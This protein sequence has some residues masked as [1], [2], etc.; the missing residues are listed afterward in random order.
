MKNLTI[1]LIIMLLCSGYGGKINARAR[2]L[3]RRHDQAVSRANYHQRMM[4]RYNDRA[5]YYA[6][7][8]RESERR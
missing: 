2:Q 6:R 7:R 5:A 3:W 1:I 4:Y 8:A